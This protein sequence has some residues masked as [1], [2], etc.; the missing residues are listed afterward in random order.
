MNKIV[1]DYDIL[2]ALLQ[3]Y[4]P[5]HMLVKNMIKSI[6]RR[7]TFY[8][9]EHIF[10]KTIDLCTDFDDKIKENV[11]YTLTNACRIQHLNPVI[12]NDALKNFVS[13]SSLEYCDCLTLEFMKS[14]NIYNILSFNE[15]LDDVHGINRVYDFDVVNKKRLNFIKYE[16]N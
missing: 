12:Y 10:T 7:F 1:L 15:K 16:E 8:I 4:H 6:N 2:K 11:G 3:L 13:S 9:P 5:K 14:R